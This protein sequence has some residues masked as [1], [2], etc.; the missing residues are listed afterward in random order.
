[1]ETKNEPLSAQQSLALIESMIKQA[2]GKVSDNSF[3]FLVWGW[4]IALCN[5]AMYYIMKFTPYPNYA[6]AVSR[7]CRVL[8]AAMVSR[9]ILL[10]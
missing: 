8:A 2:K 4:V 3:Y 6:P 7:L 10:N 5:F 1:M 9:I